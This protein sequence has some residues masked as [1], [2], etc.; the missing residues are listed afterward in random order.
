MEHLNSY[1]YKYDFVSP[2]QLIAI[3][4]EELKSYYDTGAIDD[5]LFPIY[6]DNCLRKLGKGSYDIKPAI[7]TIQN[8]SSELPEDFL[9]IREA[10]L[11][12]DVTSSYKLPGAV[13]QQ[14]DTCSTRIDTPDVYCTAC[15]ECDMPDTIKAVYKTTGTAFAYYHKDYLL[16]PEGTSSGRNVYKINRKKIFV[17]FESGTVYALYYSKETDCDGY[18]MIPDNFRIKQYI[19]FYL[20]YKAYEQLANQ[21]T[22]ETF[23]QI[24]NKAQ[25]YERKCDEAYIDALTESKKETVYDKQRKMINQRRRLNKFN[26]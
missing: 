26:L 13:Y 21:V 23:N 8:Y 6:I 4:K 19:E 15:D 20:K 24:N 14:I 25:Q 12:V 16:Y 9:S 17:E 10:W 2:Q 3:V 1:Y 11:C 5:V 22:D 18:S 7:F